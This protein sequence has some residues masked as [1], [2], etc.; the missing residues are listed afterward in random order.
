[1]AKQT[2][3]YLGP[4][5][6]QGEDF[7]PIVT[8]LA[9]D[10]WKKR[11]Y[12]IATGR[13][14]PGEPGYENP[15]KAM[16]EVIA[17]SPLASKVAEMVDLTKHG[18]PF[19]PQPKDA[20]KPSGA[21]AKLSEAMATAG[22]AIGDIELPGY[23]RSYRLGDQMGAGAELMEQAWGAPQPMGG[24]DGVVS[25]GDVLT[26]RQNVTDIPFLS[27]AYGMLKSGSV[28]QAME[29][30]KSY[31]SNEDTSPEAAEQYEKNLSTVRAWLRQQA[32][33][34]E[35]Q[36]DTGGMIAEGVR[37][38][39][40]YIAEFMMT[41]GTSAA[42]G[43]AARANAKKVLGKY[44]K[45]KAGR[46]AAKG[47]G[48]LAAAT[49]QTALMAPRVG[50]AVA[51][52]MLPQGVE[53]GPMG[54]LRVTEEGEGLAEAT[55]KGFLDV[56]VENVAER[57]G[58]TIGRGLGGAVAKIP[59]ASKM[60][61]R[62]RIAMKQA[63]R[64]AM[65]KTA[66]GG[67]DAA[68]KA[69][70]WDGIVNEL[71]E[72]EL[73]RVLRAALTV[74]DYKMLTAQERVAELGTLAA[75]PAVV[76][77]P[78]A[79]AAGGKAVADR[80]KKKRDAKE[81]NV[82][83]A[84]AGE[85]VSR[86]QELGWD[87][88]IA[89]EI[90]ADRE[91][92][93]DIL[94]NEIAA[95][96]VQPG[97]AAGI[98][99]EQAAESKAQ[100]EA[101]LETPAE[102][103]AETPQQPQEHR[104]A[105]EPADTR[106]EAETPQEA[107]EGDTKPIV[108][109]EPEAPD[110][111]PE[112]DVVEPEVETPKEP[113]P[114]V[115]AQEEDL[116]SLS[117]RELQKRA[118][119]SGIKANQKKRELVRQLAAA[120]PETPT[121]DTGETIET[122]A[123][124]DDGPIDLGDTDKRVVSR[125]A[126]EKAT[127]RIADRLNRLSANPL[128]PIVLAD[129]AVAGAYHFEN[130]VRKFAAWS[131]KMVEDYGEKVKPYLRRTW[132]D[133]KT[134]RKGIERGERAESKRLLTTVQRRRRR[135]AAKALGRLP[136]TERVPKTARQLLKNTMQRMQTASATAWLESAKNTVAT[137]K[138][139]AAYAKNK[140]AATDL[141]EAQRN[142]ILSIIAKARTPAEQA[143]AIAAVDME[144][145]RAER[146]AAIKELE[147]TIKE[148]EK[149]KLRP[150]FQEQMDALLEG[151]S[152]TRRTSKTISRAESLLNAVDDGERDM[153]ERLAIPKALIAQ[154]KEIVKSQDKQQIRDLTAREVRHL[155]DM[156]KSIIHVNTT[157][158]RI[159]FG[160]EARQRDEVESQ[161]VDEVAEVHE[162]KYRSKDAE[163]EAGEKPSKYERL[164]WE[165]LT[166][167][168]AVMRLTGQR[169]GIGHRVLYADLQRSNEQFYRG[170]Q[171]AQE[172]IREALSDA[173][174]TPTI[175][176][177]RRMS[178]T[179][180]HSQTKK[181]NVPIRKFN[182]SNGTVSLTSGERI[183]LYASL[184]DSST[185]RQILNEKV[186]V[187]MEYS[188]GA[189]STVLT[190]TDVR[191]LMRGVTAKE[192]QIADAMRS[193]I[194]GVMKERI[195]R[196]WVEDNGYELAKADDYFPRLRSRKAADTGTPDVLED[197]RDQQLDERGIF[198]GRTG[199]KQP[200]VIGD[201]FSAFFRYVNSANSYIYKGRAVRNANMLLGSGAVKVALR[202][203]VGSQALSYFQELLK[204]YKGLEHLD[205]GEYDRALNQLLRG[206]H[207]AHLGA[208]P[209]VMF[210]QVVSLLNAS[211]EL[212][213]MEIAKHLNKSVSKQVTREI[214]KHGASLKARL[215]GS[216][217]QILSAH[218][219]PNQ[220]ELFYTGK[221][222]SAVTR[223]AM[224]G[225]H[226][227]DA[228]AIRVIWAAAKAEVSKRRSDHGSPE[229]WEAV[230]ARAVQVVNRTQPTF[231][232]LNMTPLL[233]KGRRNRWLKLFLMYTS[234]RSKNLSM[235]F[236]AAQEMKRGSKAKALKIW[237]PA[238]IGSAFMIE[239]IHRYV[240]YDKL[241][242]GD[243]E[244]RPETL[245]DP[246]AMRGVSYRQLQKWAQAYGLKA[247]GTRE[248]LIDRLQEI[249]GRSAFTQFML[250]EGVPIAQGTMGRLLGNIPIGGKTLSEL[251]KNVG[252][253]AMGKN[254]NLYWTRI[255]AQTPVTGIAV[256]TVEALTF[257][258]AG[259]WRKAIDA[260]TE[261]I[262]AVLKL[263]T[264]FLKR[265]SKDLFEW[266]KLPE[267]R[268]EATPTPP[269]GDDPLSNKPVPR[270]WYLARR[271]ELMSSTEARQL[272]K[273]RREY[274]NAESEA[275]RKKAADAYRDKAKTL[276]PALKTKV[277]GKKKQRNKV[278]EAVRK[279]WNVPKDVLEKY[280][281]EPWADA[282]LKRLEARNA[283]RSRK[284]RRNR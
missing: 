256:D 257:L 36:R 55:V 111:V 120:Q 258:V 63:W 4:A 46:L 44:A 3:E 215:D 23:T 38:T 27:G 236:R 9:D 131:K 103:A 235:H 137:H 195:N 89:N 183:F 177:L 136:E 132:K 268:K 92:A 204:D 129:L 193:Y 155:V 93:A 232:P 113:A 198:L 220:L 101:A 278:R 121:P 219:S 141:T 173:G 105:I 230:N 192:K 175:R 185:L 139:L 265:L 218:L 130:G 81:L 244:K 245:P 34:A 201:A 243:E 233:R 75:L 158:N 146:R 114:D 39:L 115:V 40:P 212:G 170:E 58:E 227:A 189:Q 135:K 95:P 280:K 60:L 30:I 17:E 14:V 104:E 199:G 1:M 52:R 251:G 2:G 279:G 116:G 66:R 246:G 83:D 283:G 264:E 239:M 18:V 54:T 45:G 188:T 164:V 145:E 203:R 28:V 221:E 222:G 214:R 5:T 68:W 194:N 178:R 53:A 65:P 200:L 7:E 25:A 197:F 228:M 253:V 272:R 102:A 6:G 99:P 241:F 262:G 69:M 112:A 29:G 78:A 151:F 67:F 88:D 205:Q 223:L 100:P 176:V 82:A 32:E 12:H 207:V 109:T 240:D 213:A 106:L 209:K 11:K 237:V 242:G 186:P 50:E 147:D 163:G 225:I 259:R 138:D 43:K 35:D 123:P 31:Q 21:M 270:F 247:S 261:P 248:E 165:N 216:G 206:L 91:L 267:N 275:Q 48:G 157:K 263:P 162:P 8:P 250:D 127:S 254:P 277:E 180:V 59:G 181:K 37:K 47:V 166:P 110:V 108:E 234:Q 77:G 169:E 260:S 224:K 150:E 154:A 274:D 202:E 125:K 51:N 70:R 61:K 134:A 276:L 87:A 98:A 97:D 271:W 73:G 184:M 84:D 273:F 252:D 161:F 160:R 281:G 144:A 182:L 49:K 143:H 118:K 80:R 94:E 56:L 124:A 217:M 249:R 196:R 229:F 282:A 208:N 159:L 20:K 231:D 187:E 19:A 22:E 24:D 171:E 96:Q 119:A 168:D 142:R 122:A 148:A 269:W 26:D 211:T 284:T 64:G 41:A 62:V 152:L 174:V 85:L 76:G 210:Y 117:Y 226:E 238:L 191:K 128:D 16:R 153:T 190:E 140:L 255:M 172:H 10:P 266:H 13:L 74:E 42:L 126:Y 57:A 149:T 33:M 179:F 71:G 167:E 133:L 90:A 86:L 107:V 156:A 72:E 79:V 15:K